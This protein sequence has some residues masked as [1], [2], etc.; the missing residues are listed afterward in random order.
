VYT[1]NGAEGRP[2][3]KKKKLARPLGCGEQ[4]Q[5]DVGV[6][7]QDTHNDSTLYPHFNIV[8]EPDY[9]LRPL[10]GQRSERIELHDNAT[11]GDVPAAD[12]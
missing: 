4:L 6:S 1:Q 3:R 10:V 5:R 11:C 9:D 7:G 8:V 12:F 2:N